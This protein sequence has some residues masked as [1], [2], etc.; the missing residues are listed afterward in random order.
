MKIKSK[1]DLILLLVDIVML[2]VLLINLNLIVFDW[3]FLSITVQ[4]LLN[5]YVPDF[6]QFYMTRIHRDF[7]RIDLIFVAIFLAEFMLRWG[8]AIYQRT[9]Y[10]WFFYP[11][12]HWYDLIGCIPVGSLRFLRLLRIIGIA[13]RLHKLKIIDLTKSYIYHQGVKYYQIIVE[14]ISDRVVVNVIRDLQAEIQSGNPATQRIIREVVL[15][16]KENIVAWFSHRLQHIAAKAYE[17]YKTDLEVYMRERIHE[18]VKTNPEIAMLN[19]IPIF[20]KM[21]SGN[22]EKAISDI[23]FGVISGL[24]A[25]LASERS[26]AVVEDV[27]DIAIDAVMQEEE[28]RRLE[29]IINN[30]LVDALEIVKEQVQIQQWKLREQ[31]E[32]AARNSPAT[33]SA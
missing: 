7:V 1:S 18:A 21:V 12:I 5:Q 32:K 11:F 8:F 13:I 19:H 29:A 28:D 17:S 10:K 16:Q 27:T 31:A 15:P 4:N 6:Y 14:E 30:A 23:T 24:I 22:L 2:V 9:Y 20:G 25:D 3:I 33:E 26:K